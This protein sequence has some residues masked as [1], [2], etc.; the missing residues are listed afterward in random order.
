[1]IW[2][3]D[4][5]SLLNLVCSV[6]LAIVKHNLLFSNHIKQ[7]PLKRWSENRF[8]LGPSRGISTNNIRNVFKTVLQSY[9]ESFAIHQMRW[10]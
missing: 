2:N 1:M 5:S 7:Y 3:D 9:P 6:R 8:P 10:A 4:I